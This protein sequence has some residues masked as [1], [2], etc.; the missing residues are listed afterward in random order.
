MQELAMTDEYDKFVK[1][2]ILLAYMIT[3]QSR[4][5]EMIILMH[6]MELKKM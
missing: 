6:Q 3:F 1:R 5:L 2:S 4:T